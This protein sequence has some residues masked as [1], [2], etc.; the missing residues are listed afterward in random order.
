MDLQ[1]IGTIA[2]VIAGVVGALFSLRKVLS[3]VQSWKQKRQDKINKEEKKY[4]MIEKMCI[5]L[6]PNGG[7]SIKD[8]INRIEKD[9]AS[10]KFWRRSMNDL[11]PRAIFIS[12]KSGHTTWVNGAYLRLVDR[13]LQQV[14]GNQWLNSIHPE[15]RTVVR[16]EWRLAVEEKRNFEMSYSYIVDGKPLPVKCVAVFEEDHGYFGVVTPVEFI[17]RRTGDVQEK[18]K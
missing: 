9:I 3:A 5:E 18:Q 17:D 15:F 7:K 10:L 13:T 8:C 12:D 14:R 16:T 11:D 4:L 1:T 6:S 2:G